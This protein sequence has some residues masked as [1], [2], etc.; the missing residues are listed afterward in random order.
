[1]KIDF[2][3]IF[4]FHL[5]R[6]KRFCRLR[7][8]TSPP[9]PRVERLESDFNLFHW[10]RAVEEEVGKRASKPLRFFPK[11]SF[12]FYKT[13][14]EK[15]R[16]FSPRNVVV[17]ATFVWKLIVHVRLESPRNFRSRA[18]ESSDKI[19]CNRAVRP[20]SPPNDMPMMF[21]PIF[22]RSK[23]VPSEPKIYRRQRLSYGKLM[24]AP[25]MRYDKTQTEKKTFSKYRFLNRVY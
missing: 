14:D 18:S 7:R 11:V 2:Y 12:P 24:R 8:P 5:G 9:R 21:S 16:D 6:L 13:R 19:A 1:M 4:F 23:T 10:L 3:C 25:I 20:C 22:V 17:A 15:K